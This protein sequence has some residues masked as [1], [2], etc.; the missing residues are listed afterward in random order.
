MMKSEVERAAV[1]YGQYRYRLERWWGRTKAPMVFLMLNPSTA[2][3]EQDDATIRVCM[4]RARQENCGGIVVANL[5]AYRATQPAD[6]KRAADP[7]GPLN[8]Q[9][10]REAIS[11]PG[12]IVV[13]AWGADGRYAYRHSTVMALVRDA[14]CDLYAIAFTKDGDPRH[15]LRLPYAKPLERWK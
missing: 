7:I 15:P 1:I 2:D 8:D 13:A 4:G 5:F 11:L 14:G 10:I 3:A 12:A 6:M 9:H